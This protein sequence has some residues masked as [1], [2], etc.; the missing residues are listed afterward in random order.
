MEDSNVQDTQTA[1]YSKVDGAYTPAS[2]GAYIKGTDIKPQYASYY[3]S[4]LTDGYL[5]GNQ[6]SITLELPYYAS[7]KSR[8]AAS[9]SEITFEFP[10]YRV[11]KLDVDNNLL[12][13]VATYARSA[14]EGTS[15][16]GTND[17]FVRFEPGDSD[18]TG[19]F[20]SLYYERYLYLNARLNKSSGTLYRAA[21]FDKSGK[22]S[23][24]N[25][26]IEDQL[27]RVNKK[28]FTSI[29]VEW[30]SELSYF[31][32]QMLEKMNTFFPRKL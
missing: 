27:K 5:Q 1:R 29:P 18:V 2:D 22:I 14:L 9:G 21:Q 28:Y 3:T 6:R 17:Y 16:N 31:K 20:N 15:P 23:T 30:A 4:L 24:T 7:N 25:N 32:P 8:L 11:E 19:R 12:E 10:P 13:G 26:A